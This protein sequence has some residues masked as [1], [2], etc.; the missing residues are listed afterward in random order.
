MNFYLPLRGFVT[1]KIFKIEN[2]SSRGSH[3][4]RATAD[5]DQQLTA[6]RGEV[7]VTQP[8]V[9]IRERNFGARSGRTSEIKNGDGFFASHAS[10][11][12]PLQRVDRQETASRFK[13]YLFPPFKVYNSQW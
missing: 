12:V 1:S 6:V 13:T 9:G 4:A 10:D 3:H 8:R 5:C 11:E 2:Q 7:R